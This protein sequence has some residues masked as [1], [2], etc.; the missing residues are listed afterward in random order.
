[1]EYFSSTEES[2]PEM[3]PMERKI[4]GRD[5]PAVAV[6]ALCIRKTLS[7]LRETEFQQ[8][9]DASPYNTYVRER[10]KYARKGESPGSST[11]YFA[12]GERLALFLRLR[13]MGL[14]VRIAYKISLKKTP[15]VEESL[16]VVTGL[17]VFSDSTF[18]RKECIHVSIDSFGKILNHTIYSPKKVSEAV[19]E[20]ISRNTDPAC[21]FYAYDQKHLEQ[22]PVTLREGLSHP[23]YRVNPSHPRYII[24]PRSIGSVGHIKDRTKRHASKSKAQKEA[25]LR[26]Y[27]ISHLHKLLTLGE[28]L[29]MNRNI[30][31]ETEPYRI[32]R[33]S[34]PEKPEIKLYAPWQIEEVPASESLLA[35][36]QDVPDGMVYLMETGVVQYN[37]QKGTI[38]VIGSVYDYIT[39]RRERVSSGVL[40][41]EN[42]LRKEMPEIVKN[43]HRAL[44]KAITEQN[45][46]LILN[47]QVFTKLALRYIGILE[48]L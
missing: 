46:A 25:S 21:P 6:L 37:L 20:T 34:T 24:Y 22:L 15:S 48:S 40:L 33:G 2:E 47:M 16:E 31:P 28:V 4:R 18:S 26:I 43:T 1:M 42:D 11:A 12:E 23:L 19:S 35:T 9:S 32:V 39:G 17:S 27:P 36:P 30:R 38:P 5:L 14:H 45:K 29:R 13:T 7:P 3:A 10:E 8:S 44:I 41:T